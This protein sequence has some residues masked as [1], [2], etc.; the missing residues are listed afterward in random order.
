MVEP[1]LRAL[2]LIWMFPSDKTCAPSVLFSWPL[3]V[4]SPPREAMTAAAPA[5]MRCVVVAVMAML[6]P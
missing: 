3:M 2:P 6:S 5:P 1:S 4:T